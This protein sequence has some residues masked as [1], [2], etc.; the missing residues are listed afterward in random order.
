MHTPLA[1]VLPMAAAPAD[2]T[3]LNAI[4]KDGSRIVRVERLD[5]RFVGPDRDYRDDELF[6]FL[7]PSAEAEERQQI[8]DDHFAEY[9]ADRS[10]G[11]EV[12]A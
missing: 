8:T 6:G 2:G 1:N 3:L 12:D 9:D 4:S 7:V 10:V 11:R 5:G